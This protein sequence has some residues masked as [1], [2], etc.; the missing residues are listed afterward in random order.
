[1]KRRRNLAS[2]IPKILV[3]FIVLTVTL[4]IVPPQADAKDKRT[5]VQ[6]GDLKYAMSLP[7]A[8][9]KDFLEGQMK[10]NYRPYPVLDLPGKFLVFARDRGCTTPEDWIK[11][12]RE[13]NL[14]TYYGTFTIEKEEPANA[15]KH[16]A[17][18]Y[19]LIDIQGKE[20]YA[21][22]ESII[23]TD[24][25]VVM[26][27]YLYDS[28]ESDSV[29]EEM[30]AILSSF[31][32]DPEQVENARN[33]Y[34]HGRTV[35]FC[36]LGLYLRMPEGWIPDDPGCTEK[37]ITVKLPSEGT[38]EIIAFMRVANGIPSVMDL[39]SDNIRGL[40]FSEETESFA[41]GVKKAEA[42]R[43]KAGMKKEATDKHCI[44][45]LVD[46]GGYALILS[47]NSEV[48][49]DLLRR[50]GANA[51][52]LEAKEAEAMRLAALDE[53]KTALKTKNP[54]GVCEALSTLELFSNCDKTARKIK[55]GFKST[56]EIQAECALSIGRMACK[57][58]RSL[59][60]KPLRDKKVCDSTKR[61]CIKA[62][63]MI[64]TSQARKTL[65]E[66]KKK[67]SLGFSDELKEAIDESLRHFS[68]KPKSSKKKRRG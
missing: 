60:E 31:S 37:V 61:A 2:S 36:K 34:T 9:K 43:V 42:V 11:F 32:S 55:D 38:L 8:W 19:H 64:G 40:E 3:L 12:H 57:C 18:L 35:S 51:L 22:A 68:Y 58:S 44:L 28:Y 50:I 6:I 66:L 65:E 62:L 49:I 39:T 5:L 16:A 63:T 54:D 17:H 33:I 56:E 46:K 52:L 48:E 10:L 29:L 14:P 4:S 45:G 26:I 67:S 13:T 15:G 27:S 1:M 20:G 41:F 24:S 53:F 25:H 59:L 23:F 21:A 7:S 30:N 47:S